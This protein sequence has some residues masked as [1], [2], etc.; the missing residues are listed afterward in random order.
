MR[1]VAEVHESFAT[2]WERVADAIPDA[3]A[4]VQGDRRITYH[5]IEDPRRAPR[6]GVVRPRGRT[7][8][9]R[10]RC[11]CTTAPSTWSACSRCR[12]CGR[13]PANVNF[14]YLGDELAQL[15][16]NADAEVLV[17]HR[18]L[19]DRVLDAR[20]RMPTLRHVVELDDDHG[21]SDLRGAPAQPRPRPAH[22]ALGRRPPALVHRRNHRPAQG[23]ALAPGHA[24]RVRPRRRVRT[25]GRD[26]HRF[27]RSTRRRRAPVASA[28]HPARLVAHHPA[29]ARHR[30]APGQHRVRGR[31]HHRAPRTRPHRRRHHLRDHR[32]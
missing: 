15:V 9:P 14:R 21:D 4:V 18:S 29:G 25:A 19:R 11:S 17:H 13:V 27:D 6:V 3:P 10:S 30:G 20:D 28:W 26:T 7:A 2:V 1:R 5:A 8:T 22:R 16:D 12:S 23:C 24:A 32:A 31:R